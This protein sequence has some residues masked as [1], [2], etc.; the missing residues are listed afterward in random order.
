M[1][2]IEKYLAEIYF[3]PKHPASFSG[4]NKFYNFV[5]RDDKHNVSKGKIGRWLR[6]Q[7][8][9]SLHK[10]VIRPKRTPIEVA[11][12]D[13][14]WSADLMDMSKF[15]R[16]NNG[17]KF[18]LVII[19]TFSKYLWVLPLKNKTGATVAEAF[20]KV[21]DE[22]RMPKR[23]RTDKGQ[24]FR[25]N[26]VK[27]LLA[28]KGI[29]QLFTQNEAK[30]AVAERVIKTIKSKIYRYLTYKNSHSYI[31]KLPEFVSSYNKTV[32]GTTKYRPVDV[33]V[34][35]QEDVRFSTFLSKRSKHP[36]TLKPYKFRLGDK[37]RIS[38]LKNTFSREYDHK[39]SGEVFKVTRRFRRSGIPVYKLS[40]YNNEAI[41]G[42]FYQ[43]ELA[44]ADLDDDQM[45]KIEKVIKE[46]GQGKNKELF[47][48]W[49]YWPSKFNEW[50]KASD[51]EA[52]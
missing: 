8:A 30:A 3:D 38:Y 52:I 48:K 45:F 6:R 16:Q 41:S 51:V 13:D 12:I 2:N 7:E 19:D 17:I 33:N 20:Q 9:Y 14:Q 25:A 44:L 31:D 47:V 49:L 40:D 50:I 15:S 21:L 10:P 35:N 37:V 34:N 43:N 28:S 18:L 36:F 32:H 4:L 1:D 11:G 23:L 5:K 46:R 24:E 39:W 27:T 29:K 42:T 26:I 22:G